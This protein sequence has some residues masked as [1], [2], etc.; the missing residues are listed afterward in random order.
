MNRA[1]L[2]KNLMTT[3]LPNSNKWIISFI[4][5]E[6]ITLR[7]DWLCET[8]LEASRKTASVAAFASRALLSS[9]PSLK[10]PS[11]EV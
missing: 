2:K 5:S 9:F 11:C 10:S 8:G 6:V 7:A 1:C 4:V 3:P